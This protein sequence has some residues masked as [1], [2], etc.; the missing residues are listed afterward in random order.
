VS[1]SGTPPDLVKHLFSFERLQLTKRH[2]S[3]RPGEPS[4]LIITLPLDRLRFAA[5][6]KLPFPRQR[7]TPYNKPVDV[8]GQKMTEPPQHHTHLRTVPLTRTGSGRNSQSI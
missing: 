6:I 5:A 7:A 2:P 3:R 8:R 1:V 4:R